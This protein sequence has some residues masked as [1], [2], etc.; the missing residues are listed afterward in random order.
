MSCS[1]VFRMDLGRDLEQSRRRVAKAQ[2]MMGRAAPMPTLDSRL[3]L[4]STQDYPCR[5]VV[6]QGIGIHLSNP[7]RLGEAPI[8]MRGYGRRAGRRALLL[9]EISFRRAD[10]RAERKTLHG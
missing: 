2:K 5:R 9:P 1:G 4:V 3:V 6:A 10:T 7:S 8:G